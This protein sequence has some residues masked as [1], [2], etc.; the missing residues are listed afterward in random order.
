MKEDEEAT[1][2]FN[3]RFPP[4]LLEEMDKWVKA[5]YYTSKAEFIKDAIRSKFTQLVEEKKFSQLNLEVKR[6]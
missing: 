3:V 4:A 5:G 1:V 2:Q 6:P